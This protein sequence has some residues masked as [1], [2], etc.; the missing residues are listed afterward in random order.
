[1]N[2]SMGSTTADLK[3]L[4]ENFSLSAEECIGVKVDKGAETKIMNK[5]KLCL[6]GNYSLIR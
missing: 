4:C 2:K 6:G 1:M 5:G 3:K